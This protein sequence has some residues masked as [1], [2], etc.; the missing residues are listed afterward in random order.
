MLK[1]LKRLR[2][3]AQRLQ[4]TNKAALVNFGNGVQVL[5]RLKFGLNSLKR[6]KKFLKDFKKALKI[7]E[8]SKRLELK[9]LKS[10][11]DIKV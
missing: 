3:S 8:K 10:R 9:R 11:K 7:L 4:K 6:Y 5:K 1:A 2:K